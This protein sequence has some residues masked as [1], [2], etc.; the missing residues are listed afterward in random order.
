M[1]LSAYG[2]M[3]ISN[4]SSHPPKLLVDQGWG[5]GWQ[6][7]FASHPTSLMT[8]FALEDSVRMAVGEVRGRSATVLLQDQLFPAL[9]LWIH[10]F[11]KITLY[12]F[13]NYPRFKNLRLFDLPRECHIIS[14]VH[15]ERRG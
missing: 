8:V 13:F 2:S 3:M 7:Q 5:A 12:S 4:L 15:G 1:G 9:A 6:F 10:V 11:F 14:L